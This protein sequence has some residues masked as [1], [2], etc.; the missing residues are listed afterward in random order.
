MPKVKGQEEPTAPRRFHPAD[1][2]AFLEDLKTDLPANE[3][4]DKPRVRAAARKVPV[5]VETAGASTPPGKPNLEKVLGQSPNEPPANMRTIQHAKR[6][7]WPWGWTIGGLVILSGA[8][9]GGF[10]FFNQAQR[11]SGERVNLQLQLPS[12]AASGS[13]LEL[14]V[15]FQNLEPVDLSRAEVT[16]EYPEGFTVE[17]TSQPATNEFQN[18]FELGTL[19]SGRAGSLTVRGQIFGSVGT[20]RT[21]TAT[22]TFRAENF[23]SDFQTTAD[24]KVKITTSILDLKLEGP[25]KL[26]P[27]AS[28]TWKITYGNTSA[29]DLENVQIEI[30]YPDGLT[31]T[32][33]DPAAVERSALWRFEKVA[34]DS[35]GSISVTATAEGDVGDALELIVRAGLVSTSNAVDLQAE[36]KLL[37]LMIESGVSAPVTVNGQ[38]ENSVAEPG[39]TLN[40]TLRVS[41]DG[42][43][44][45]TDVSV[46]VDL[47]G[48]VINLE[49]LENPAN[50]TVE[51]R[52]LSWTKD[53]VVGLALLKPGQEATIRFAV[54]SH[55]T[56]TVDSDDDVNPT[57]TLE[58]RVT[59]PNLPAQAGAPPTTRFVT[60]LATVFGFEAEARY[61][62][63]EGAVLGTGSVP[64]KVG[65]TTAYRIFW[66]ITSTTNDATNLIVSATLPTGVFWTGQ[67]VSRDA[68]DIKFEAGT[69]TVSWTLNKIPA[70]TGSRLPVLIASFEV[71]ITP[72][73][74]QVGDVVV[75]TQ[76]SA[77]T[78]KDAFTSRDLNVTQPTLTTDL[79]DDPVAVDNGEVAV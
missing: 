4:I 58:V 38:S 6:R 17:S 78:A 15:K 5:N 67:H 7:G 79:P 41:N 46:Q 22:L 69:R 57:V 2:E 31:P 53:Q 8:A 21:F 59:S 63:D 42:E 35:Q 68:G 60:K 39:E 34:Q 1:R 36:Q 48:Q 13:E 77:A 18:A 10:F 50:A 30:I 52:K 19:K 72:T 61:A 74:D 64:P 76:T 16:I 12:E 29:R 62:D 75:L 14:T 56:L 55:S 9:V 45:L 37:I 43:I 40:Y 33:T 71:S 51:D 66:R 73:A 25:S 20:D 3:S 32:A 44:E 28:G 11:F 23:S 27:G 49:T 70:G 24:T 26:T 65:Q 54:D 47:I